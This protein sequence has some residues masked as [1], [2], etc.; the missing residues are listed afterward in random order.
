MYRRI[1]YDLTVKVGNQPPVANAGP[2]QVVEQSN[3]AGA[4]VTLNGSL[5]TDDGLILPLNY[6]WTWTGG[7]AS[8][9]NPI[10][11]FPL[12]TTPSNFFMDC[13]RWAAFEYRYR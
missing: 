5:S 10:V 6:T 8:D 7:S 2:D 9:V 12:G 11:T 3:L 4:A 1:L 13:I